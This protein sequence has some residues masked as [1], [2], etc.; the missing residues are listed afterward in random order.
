MLL[1][2][3][4]VIIVLKMIFLML[5]LQLLLGNA[6]EVRCGLWLSIQEASTVGAACFSD[7]VF[8]IKKR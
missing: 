5:W 7:S 8:R 4:V 6:A 3:L 2:I 1:L